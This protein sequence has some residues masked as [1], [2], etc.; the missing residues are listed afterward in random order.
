MGNRKPLLK[1]GSKV[2]LLW[3]SQEPF[4]DHLGTPKEPSGHTPLT[5][6]GNTK[7]HP[8][9]SRGPTGNALWARVARVD[10]TRNGC[11]FIGS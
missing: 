7:E 2:R 3:N 11:H 1:P 5:T 4:G 9:T 6:P 8:R 10:V